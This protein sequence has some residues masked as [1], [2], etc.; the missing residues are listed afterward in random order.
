MIFLTIGTHEPFDRLVKAVD[1]IA[2]EIP[3]TEIVAQLSNTD[4]QIRSGNI[5]VKSFIAPSEFTAYCTRA[6]FIIGHAGMGTI[7]TALEMG[8]TIIVFPRKADLRETRND[9]QVATVKKLEELNYIYVAYN[10]S[11]LRALI[12]KAKNGNLKPLHTIGN[13]A[14]PKLLD[15]VKDFINS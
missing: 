2:P 11:E 12:L 13:Y 1:E 15:A 8:K 7:I 4:Y 14:S 3:D 9:H 6:E 10:E 5:E